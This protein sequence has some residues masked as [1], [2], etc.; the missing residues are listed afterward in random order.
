MSYYFNGFGHYVPTERMH[1]RMVPAWI[2]TDNRVWSE[3]Y[4]LY[5]AVLPSPPPGAAPKQGDTP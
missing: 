1:Y 4:H 3:P 5:T 2:D